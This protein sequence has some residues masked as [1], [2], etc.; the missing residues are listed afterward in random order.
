MSDVA[1]LDVG[2]VA[3]SL[4]KGWMDETLTLFS[5]LLSCFALKFFDNKT[6]KSQK[7]KSAI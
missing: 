3:S 2:C 4:N 5:S 1:S 7:S 6:S